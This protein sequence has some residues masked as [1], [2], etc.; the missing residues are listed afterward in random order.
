MVD[1]KDKTTI[2]LN[3]LNERYNASHKMRERSQAFAI[4]IL[5][6]G[7]SVTWILLNG[8]GLIIAQRIIL[9]IF[10]VLIAVLAGFF[11]RSIEVGF[12]KNRRV[13]SQLE[14]ILGCYEYGLYCDKALYPEEYAHFKE[15]HQK[16][17]TRLERVSIY[18][19]SHFGSLYVW[20][21]VITMVI[22]L[23]LWVTPLQKSGQEKN[24]KNMVSVNKA[25]RLHIKRAMPE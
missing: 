1:E 10:A 9:T 5:G 25:E 18:F 6:F 3:L 22:L 2:L 4:W 14:T 21:T 23:M 7:V 13:M 12:H 20:I 15:H 24:A 11:L 16:E 19:R 17:K 8:K